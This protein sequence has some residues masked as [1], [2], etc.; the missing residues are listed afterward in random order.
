MKNSKRLLPWLAVAGWMA[1]IFAFS[2]QT[3]NRS[4]NTSGEIVRWVIGL[5]YRGF[6]ELPEAEQ[7]SVLELLQLVIRK[8]A[9]FAE[10]AV[11]AI[12]TASALRTYSLSLPLRW[13]L[14]VAI[15]A[16]YAVTD[17]IH[18][19]FVPDRAC[20]LLDVGIDTA[21]ALFGTAVFVLLGYILKRISR[22]S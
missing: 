3:G 20:R 13:C 22:K 2:A 19:Y 5:L 10:Y 11:L 14:P 7:A 12:L 1:V 16:L 21:G 15:S 17:E 18:Q 8:G 6:G 9:H 4:G